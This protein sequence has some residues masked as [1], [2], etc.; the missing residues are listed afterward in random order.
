MLS[1][2]DA[3]AKEG[4]DVLG[5]ILLYGNVN[6]LGNFSLSFALFLSS[7][8]RSRWPLR[9]SVNIYPMKERSIDS[10]IH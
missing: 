9:P 4:V 7:D 10:F 2:Y 5:K 3:V 1:C 8:L 6:L